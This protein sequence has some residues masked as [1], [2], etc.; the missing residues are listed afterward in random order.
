MNNK[1]TTII[2][3]LKKTKKNLVNSN[4][5]NSNVVKTMNNIEKLSKTIECLENFNK[6]NSVI[7]L[8]PSMNA[9]KIHKINGNGE[10]FYSAIAY[11]LGKT[12]H[13]FKAIIIARIFDYSNNYQNNTSFNGVIRKSGLEAFKKILIDTAINII[14]TIENNKLKN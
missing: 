6:L 12:T 2:T 11:T 3:N 13:D 10:C 4:I 8:P 14:N 9:F 5:S 1:I 7:K